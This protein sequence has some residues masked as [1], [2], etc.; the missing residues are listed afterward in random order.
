M[1]TIR[2]PFMLML[3][4]VFSI[5]SAQTSKS[6]LLKADGAILEPVSPILVQWGT[7][8]KSGGQI[9]RWYNFI[10]SSAYGGVPYLSIAN[11]TL[12]PDSSVVQSYQ[13]DSSMTYLGQTGLHNV[14]QLFDPKS[15]YYDEILSEY[16]SYTI[17]SIELAFKYKH[18]LPGTVDTLDIRFYSDKAIYKGNIVN[19]N[20]EVVEPTAWILYNPSLGIGTG[21]VQHFQYLLTASDTGIDSYQKRKIGLSSM[22]HISA[23]GLAAVSYRFIPGYTWNSGD[24]I[25]HDWS[26]PEPTH[27][28]NQFIPMIVRDSSK[29]YEQSYNLGQTIRTAHRLYT[30][31]NWDN[32][33]TPGNAWLEFNEHVYCSFHISYITGVTKFETVNN[34]QAYPNP[35]HANVDLTI[36]FSLSDKADVTID[37]FDMQGKKVK[38]VSDNQIQT[39]RHELSI[40]TSDLQNGLYTFTISTGQ[41][42][43]SGKVSIVR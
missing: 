37:L 19:Q 2:I 35:I 22:Q 43:T 29:T 30:V 39:G 15:F 6:D 25:Q 28:L 20:N 5:G 3:A 33:F 26:S 24:T 42:S 21:N 16:H 40:S 13:N 27:K 18:Q 32:E 11:A 10:N 38:S 36:A 17:D 4:S 14:G 8:S 7:P 12:F 9:F 31:F 41:E 1:K 23:N 34:I